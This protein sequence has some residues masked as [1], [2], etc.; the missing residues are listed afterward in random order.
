[1]RFIPF[2]DPFKPVSSFLLVI[3]CVIRPEMVGLHPF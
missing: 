3:K 2:L 1:M